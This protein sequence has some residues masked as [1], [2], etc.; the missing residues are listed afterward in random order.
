MKFL[1]IDAMA[2]G[3]VGRAVVEWIPSGIRTLAGIL[4]ERAIDYDITFAEKVIKEPGKF[5][6]TGPILLT[7]MSSDLPVIKKTVEKIK[8]I[9][10]PLLLGGPIAHGHQSELNEIAPDLAIIGEGERTFSQLLDAGLA[11][12]TV[13]EEDILS[14]IAGIAY[15]CDGS[16]KATSSPQFLTKEELNRYS[17]ST[18]AIKHYPFHENLLVVLEILRGCTNFRRVKTYHE[19]ECQENCD[20]CESDDLSLRLDCPQ[21]IPPGCGF[22]SV[23]AY[24]LLRS[25]EQ[26]LIVNEVKGLIE[27]GATKITIQVPDPLDY[28]REELVA[29]APLTDPNSPEPNYEEIERLGDMLWDLPEIADESVGITIRDVKATM[30]NDRS[31]GLLK[32]YF[33]NSIFGL[34]GETGSKEHAAFMARPYGPDKIIEAVEIFNRNG[35]KPRI[36][37][38]LGLPGQSEKTVSETIEMMKALREKVLYYDL[39]RFE[40]LPMSAFDD[41]PS[42]VGPMRDE[43]ARRLVEEVNLSQKVLFED[44]IGEEWKVVIGIYDSQKKEKQK[45]VGP[46]KIGTPKRR[47]RQLTGVA[48]YPIFDRRQLSGLDTVV[49]I[50]D[51]TGGLKSGDVATVEITGLSEHGFRVVLEGRVVE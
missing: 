13:P 12:G 25:R 47:F 34:G 29:P 19:V 22:C 18:K 21:G 23:G 33:P 49:K 41:K 9:D 20:L 10:T 2:A 35:I 40:A 17:P 11:D 31:V 28:K 3:T 42:D 26:D 45:R 27:S 32:K 50:T 38:I 15:R 16:L 46:E 1:F 6:D 8:E 36:N 24:G 7:G 37:F 14:T 48:G 51:P 4:E 44:F 39:F 30:V 43:N 5:T